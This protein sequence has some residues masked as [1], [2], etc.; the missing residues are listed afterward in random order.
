[1]TRPAGPWRTA[2][3]PGPVHPTAAPPVRATLRP[4]QLVSVRCSGLPA[5]GAPDRARR[6]HG[7]GS[8]MWTVL[9]LVI[10]APIVWALPGAQPLGGGWCPRLADQHVRLGAAG[11]ARGRRRGGRDAP[12][13]PAPESRRA[14]SCRGPL[15]L[16]GIGT[17]TPDRSR[18]PEPEAPTSFAITALRTALMSTS[19]H[20]PPAVV[21]RTSRAR[22]VGRLARRLLAMVHGHDRVF[23]DAVVAPCANGFPGARCRSPVRAEAGADGDPGP[24]PDPARG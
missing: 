16:I 9:A 23:R 2:P 15:G 24:G 12:G 20:S 19:G 18:C 7:D 17:S 3:L 21:L 22:S 5:P 14:L 10:L 1:M 8:I 11:P 13:G 4:C 6:G